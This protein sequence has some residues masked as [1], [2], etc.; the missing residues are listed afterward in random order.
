M[1][2][3]TDPG[4]QRT[5]RARMTS[6]LLAVTAPLVIIL[7]GALTLGGSRTVEGAISEGLQDRAVAGAAAIDRWLD[8]RRADVA[9][10]AAEVGPLL[11]DPDALE[12]RLAGVEG[13][14]RELAVLQVVA[15]D[16]TTLA[17]GPGET[18]LDPTDQAWFATAAQGQRRLADPYLDDGRIRLV[19]AEP[20]TDPGGRVAAVVLG[21]VR[22][23]RFGALLPSADFEAG[24]EVIV[25]TRAARL[26]YSTD[27]G[28]PDSDAALVADGAL[29]VELDRVSIE[30]ALAG[31]PGVARFVDYKGQE[32][33]GGYA[34]VGATG[35]VV[36]ARAPEVQVL[37]SQRRLLVLGLLLGVAGLAALLVFARRFAAR[38]SAFLRQVTAS[39]EDA[40]REVRDQAEQMAASAVELATTT[41]QQS[42][43][44]TETSTT[45][46]ELSR[47]AASV[48]DRAQD[49]ADRAA[50]TR[51]ALTRAESA[52][53]GAG[54]QTLELAGGV[55]RIGDI[56]ALIGELTDQTDMLALNAAIE[57][58]RAGEAGEGFAV[59]ADEVRR[60]AERSKRSAGDIAGIVAETESR[61]DAALLTMEQ[62]TKQMREGLE[63]LAE[64]AAS[65]EQV[66]TTT[67]QQQLATDQV[68]ESMVQASESSGQVAATAEQIAEGATAL[69]GTA[70]SL[71]ATASDARRRF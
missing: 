31:G 15:P 35:L 22:V 59:V 16:G 39:T 70:G 52:L 1:D 53:D 8:E 12:R 21:G 29:T 44:V 6:G 4:R 51:D 42:A 69:L 20:V 62:G 33:Y 65:L 60:L 55:R 41:T 43:T 28:T 64:V 57:A 45:M 47:S 2:A 50:E 67:Q 11:E 25:G 7:V 34:P 71:E 24:G 56:L 10:V 63:Q 38:E 58:A 36:V 27:S 68:V 32:V 37:A 3:P 18:P 23:E 17:T 48:A 9:E 61:M 49:V 46:E 40:A 30:R 26:L 5:Y 19:I 66:R 14:E 13:V 54:R